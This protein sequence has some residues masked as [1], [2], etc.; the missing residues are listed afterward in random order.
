MIIVQ[1]IQLILVKHWYVFKTTELHS[2]YHKLIF[3]ILFLLA[4]K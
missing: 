4:S 1:E 3:L 2:A